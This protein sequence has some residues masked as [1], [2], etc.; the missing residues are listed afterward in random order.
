MR[1]A[2]PEHTWTSHEIQVVSRA[3][4]AAFGKPLLHAQNDLSQLGP[5]EVSS[6]TP[7]ASWLRHERSADSSRWEQ[8]EVLY[9]SDRLGLAR[10]FRN[11]RL[12]SQCR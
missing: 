4:A 8:S 5:L 1:V 7:Q 9:D 6:T 10:V 3:A 2:L 12:E 11:P